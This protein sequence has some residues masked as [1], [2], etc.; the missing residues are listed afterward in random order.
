MT[1][2]FGEKDAN[3]QSVSGDTSISVLGGTQKYLGQIKTPK[4]LSLKASWGVVKAPMG[5]VGHSWA[6]PHMLR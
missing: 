3:T 2:S 6:S 1:G 5:E 4:L